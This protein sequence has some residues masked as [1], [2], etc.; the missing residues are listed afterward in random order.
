MEELHLTLSAALPY[1]MLTIPVLTLIVFRGLQGALFRLLWC[2]AWGILAIL[3]SVSYLYNGHLT[4]A[5]GGLIFIDPFTF[6]FYLLLIGGLL[7]TLGLNFKQQ[8]LQRMS[9]EPADI[10][11]LIV[12]AV[13][14]GMAMVSAADLI[15]LFIGFELLSIC[16]YVLSGLARSERASAEAAFKYFIL[17]SFSSAFLLYGMVL[18]YASTGSMELKE[19]GRAISESNV[20]PNLLLTG[21]G[22]MLFGFAFK[23]SLAPFHFWAPDVYQGAPVPITTFMAVVVKAAAFGSFLR[24]MAVGFGS[25]D[26]VWKG[27]LWV[28]CVITMSVGNIVALRQTS[29]KRMLAYSSIAHAGYALIGFLALSKT[30]AEATLFYLLAYSIMTIG[31]FAVVLV[32][33]TGTTAQYSNDSIQSLSGL[34]WRRP[35]L[36]IGMSIFML[37]LAGM[38]PTVGFMGKLYLFKA[39]VEAGFTGLAVIAALNSLV[40]LYYYLYILKVMYFGAEEEGSLAP[41]SIPAAPAVVL[42]LSIFGTLYLGL[43][44]D[45]VF[46][47]LSEVIVG[48]Q[49]IVT[50]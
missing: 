49:A 25:I 20:P 26:G 44:S 3:F 43:F 10:D 48:S 35:F 12:C 46:K 1:V 33:T 17:G 31:S 36:G 15:V 34:G 50:R 14:G 30:G 45:S 11:A 41:L 5:L 42:A 39:A 40:S 22:L 38:P 28:L 4:Q 6:F 19:I 2:A 24:V 37:S 13:A 8:A 16:V 9:G 32:A 21:L 29:I 18:V 47:P 7:A 23:I 27:L